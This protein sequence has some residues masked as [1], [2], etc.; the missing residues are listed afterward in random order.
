M[1]KKMLGGILLMSMAVGG[2]F[3]IDMAEVR[4]AKLDKSVMVKSVKLREIEKDVWRLRIPVCEISRD[5]DYIDVVNDWAVAKKGEDGFFITPNGGFATFRLDKGREVE[6]QPHLRLF[7]AKTPRG[8]FAAIVKGLKYEY[9]QVLNVENGKYELFPRFRISKI[10]FDP[11][12][13]IVVDFYKLEGENANYSG[14][15]NLYRGYLLS[16]GRVLPLVE[17]V[18]GNPTLENTANTMYARIKF[19]RCDRRKAPPSVW[20]K[21]GYKPEMIVDHTFDDAKRIMKNFKELGM[22]D[23]EVCF[24][25]WHKDGHDGPF[26]DLFPVPE[27]FGGEAK[28]R[29]AVAYGKSLGY[30]MTVHTNHHNFYA[31][32]ARF[33]E[34]NVNKNKD[35]S[36][37]VY[38]Y[39]PGGKAYHSCF[40]TVLNRYLDEDIARLKDI[41][42]NGTYHVDVTSI[43]I[44]AP[45][46]NPLHPLNRQQMVE[47]ENKIGERLRGNFGGFSSE[48]KFDH[49]AP[50]LDYGLY[51]RW[52][53]LAKNPVIDKDIPLNELV[54]NGIILSNPYYGTIDAPYE[55]KSGESLSD[56]N[57]PYCVMGSAARARLKVVEYGGRPSFYY[58]DYSDLAPM[59]SIYA[60]WQKLKY[61]QYHFFVYHDEIAKNVFLSR[62][63]NGDEIVCNYTDK[64]FTYKGEVVESVGYKLFKAV[65]KSGGKSECVS[66]AGNS[67]AKNSLFSTSSGGAENRAGLKGST[68]V[69]LSR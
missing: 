29:E 20:N 49:V 33:D 53:N 66:A 6:K 23:I 55:R 52:D 60:D 27:E 41:G 43:R 5:V 63:D 39:W 21:E 56:M 64:P 38:T 14:V 11:Y 17:R 28:M 44:P 19:G 45:C 35:G 67:G 59:K 34:K 57:Q 30:R 47:A 25:G 3:A 58:I 8:C 37:R 2:L 7:A 1:V 42:I 24:V 26:P 31:N 50:T 15:A 54:F 51:V 32:A 48:G 16:T 9:V 61:L 65:A 22:D 10:D 68:R 46:C 18:K 12:E 62:W 69:R 13:D 36:W 4:V 40:Q